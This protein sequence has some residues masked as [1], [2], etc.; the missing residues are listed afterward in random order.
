MQINRKPGS[1]ARSQ[2][3]LLALYK[4]K[5]P[6]VKVKNL[7]GISARLIKLNGWIDIGRKRPRPHEAWYGIAGYFYYY[8]HYYGSCVLL[9]NREK[10][11][12]KAQKLAKLMLAKQEKNGSWFDFPLYDYGHAY[13]TAFALMSLHNYKKCLKKKKRAD[14]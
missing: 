5:D 3:C 4:W 9:E 1:V 8:G 10:R 7:E 2:S 14:K 6:K 12:E 13:G 11:F